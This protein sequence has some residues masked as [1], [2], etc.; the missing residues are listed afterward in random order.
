MSQTFGEKFE[1]GGFTFDTKESVLRRADLIV[2]LTPKALQALELLLRNSGQ[3]VS[4]QEMIEALWPN[5]YVE[6]SNLTVTISMLRKALG[7]N[8]NGTR[9]VE[10]VAKRGYRLVPAVKSN[11]NAGQPSD[12]NEFTSMEISRLT[13][14][15]HIMDVAISDDAE[16]LGYTLIGAGEQSLWV[17]D[18]SSGKRW[19]L[20][21][22]DPA[23][24][25]GM[26]FAHDRQSLFYI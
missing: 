10:T 13:H 12:K 25:W 19:Q 6:E 14:D 20:L 7:E 5:A 4:R 11:R 23:L 26:R 9:F 24:C 21:A 2:P 22:P 1:F 18:L 17:Q 15:G 16:L 3:V 8:E